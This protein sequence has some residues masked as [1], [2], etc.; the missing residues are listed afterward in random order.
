MVE[1]TTGLRSEGLILAES[2]ILDPEAVAIFCEAV[3]DLSDVAHAS[4]R[5]PREVQRLPREGGR[6]VLVSDYAGGRR[7]SSWLPARGDDFLPTGC[8]LHIALQAGGALRAI[9]E[10]QAGAFHGAVA[11][12][13]IALA[14]GGRVLLLEAGLGALLA[15]QPERSPEDWWREA[16]VAVPLPSVAASFGETTDACQLGILVL[17]LLLGRALEPDEY[18]GKLA[19]LLGNATETDLVG[20]RLPLGSG[21]F[22]WLSHALCL[23]TAEVPPTIPVVVDGLENLLSDLGGYVAVSEGLDAIPESLAPWPFVSDGA[24][25]ASGGHGPG[26]AHERTWP[27]MVVRPPIVPQARPAT[28]HEVDLTSSALAFDRDRTP[29]QL[30]SGLGNLDTMALEWDDFHASPSAESH[31]LTSFRRSE[32]A[33]VRTPWSPTPIRPPRAPAAPPPRR[34][35]PAAAPPQA[36][37]WTRVLRWG[38]VAVLATVA[39]AVA[40]WQWLRWQDRRAGPPTSTLEVA[41]EPGGATILINGLDRGKS[42]VSVALNPGRYEITAKSAL[43]MGTM[44]VDVAGERTRRITVP[45]QLGT[46]PGALEVNTEPGGASITLDD[47]PQGRAPIALESVPPGDHEL[48]VALGAVRVE[49][50]FTLA[51]TERLTLFVPLAGWVSVRSR[52]PLEV[53]ERGQSFGSTSSGR[54]LVPAGRRRLQLVNDEFG[55]NSAHEVTVA[56]GQVVDVPVTLPPG[57]LS[58]VTDEPAE[59]WVDGEPRG[60]TPTGTLSVPLGE[61]EVRI[62]HPRWG[63]QRLTVIVGLGAPTRLNVKLAGAEPRR[64]PQRGSPKRSGISAAR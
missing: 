59:V 42:P 44:T 28:G 19:P 61:H 30:L 58:V 9:A 11:L 4:L 52:I 17:E 56:A 3:S 1:A 64:G 48:V 8:V 33:A 15:A 55:I 29:E 62:V 7:L 35:E 31:D 14:P 26:G 2:L 18:P 47:V 27:R 40:G 5:V 13:R 20:N 49:R 46:D 50:R 63:E 37:R 25:Q 34:A 36:A 57:M 53:T 24:E 10:H 43:G 60:R 21:L 23:A 12:E 32:P 6:P 38:A 22:D 39:L 51:P 16:R 54:V 45:M 41:S